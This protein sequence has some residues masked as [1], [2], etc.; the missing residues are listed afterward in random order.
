MEFGGTVT[1]T[2]SSEKP[3][4]LK[5]KVEINGTL[6]EIT[7]QMDGVTASGGNAAALTLSLNLIDFPYGRTVFCGVDGDDSW[8]SHTVCG[9][10]CLLM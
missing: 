5:W 7:R 3:A 1:V 8:K 10:Y 2:C 9:E 4:V 6:T